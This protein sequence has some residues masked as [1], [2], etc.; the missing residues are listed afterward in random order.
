MN[1]ILVDSSYTTFY[2]FFATLRW[3]SFAHKDEYKNNNNP[4]YDW[5]NDNIF[6]E[7][8]EKMYLSSIEKLFGPKIINNSKIIFCLDS[9]RNDLWRKKINPNYKTRHDLSLKYNFKNVFNYT[10]STLIPKLL[11]N[12]I[13]SIM[14]ETIEA[15]D[16]IGAICL[17]YNNQQN[18]IINIVSGDKDF[19]QLGENVHIYNYNKSKHNFTNDEAKKNLLHK[20]LFGDK[21]DKIESIFP[22]NF[23]N[24]KQYLD[25]PDKLNKLLESNKEMKD[26]FMFNK[27][28]IDFSMIP[29]NLVKKIIKKFETLSFFSQIKK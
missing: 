4:E 21:S 12:N 18:I 20:L 11:N 28:M 9:P 23:R 22:K 17:N 2:R 14:I 8:Y 5:S 13:Y 26:K 1:I 27:L 3:Y 16:I 7:K 10:Y 6:M 29:N 19:H 25:D 15:D 24:R